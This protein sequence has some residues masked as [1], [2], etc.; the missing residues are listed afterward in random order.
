MLALADLQNSHSWGLNFYQYYNC[1]GSAQEISFR[2]NGKQALG[3]NW[4]QNA[5]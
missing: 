3:R 4:L 5:I 2:A 1:Q